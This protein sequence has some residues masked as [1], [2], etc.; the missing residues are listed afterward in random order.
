MLKKSTILLLLCALSWLAPTWA[1]TA[2]DLLTY[3]IPADAIKQSYN[4]PDLN[5]FR[6]R[7]FRRQADGTKGELVA[8]EYFTK[9]GGEEKLVKRE[10]YK[11]EPLDRV[12]PNYLHGVKREWYIN[13]QLKSEEPYRMHVRDG[14]FRHWDEKGNLVGQYQI[15]NGDG[16]LKIYNS[17]G[18]LLKEEHYKNNHVDGFKYEFYPPSEYVFGRLEQ[19]NYQGPT[20]HYLGKRIV[21]MRF[22]GP[23]GRIHGPSVEFDL[24][25][26]E[27]KKDPDLGNGLAYAGE[28]RR[29]YV[30]SRKV[31][32]AEYAQAAATDKTLPPY[33]ADI[34]QYK[35][36]VTPEVFTLAEKYRTAPRIKIPLEFDANGEPVLAPPTPIPTQ[37]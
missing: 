17:K 9:V 35:Q 29:W 36:F 12:M 13:G 4:G 31:S 26:E 27:E 6:Y 23:D 10:L 1:Q 15:N 32:E 28:A 3:S 21:S 19:D 14:L 16:V 20:V 24:R 5:I 33:F 7:Y 37:P 18:Q 2:P 8:M 11:K 25:N 30:D 34:E 22:F